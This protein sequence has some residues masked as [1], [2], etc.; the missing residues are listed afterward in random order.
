M[1]SQ[2]QKKQKADFV[3]ENHGDLQELYKQTKNLY[4]QLLHPNREPLELWIAIKLRKNQSNHQKE[5]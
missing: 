1:I 3:L 4:H 5:K 2:I